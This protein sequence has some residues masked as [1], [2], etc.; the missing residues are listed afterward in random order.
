MNVQ[1][2]W[3][4]AG[5]AIAL[6]VLA[7]NF[8]VRADFAPPPWRD[9]PTTVFAHWTFTPTGTVREHSFGPDPDG[10][11]GPIAPFMGAPF[12]PGSE[13]FLMYTPDPSMPSAPEGSAGIYEFSIPN[14]VDDFLLK[15]I[16]IQLQYTFNPGPPTGPF[17]TIGP[18]M[19]F[20][21]TAPDG[22][23]PS[24]NITQKF[25]TTPEAVP[26]GGLTYQ[27]FEDWQIVPNPDWEK[28][29]VQIP[30]GIHLDWVVVD[31][32]STVPEPAAFL[33]GGLVCCVVGVA[34]TGR[35]LLRRVRSTLA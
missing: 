20:D 9:D 31:T 12:G 33:C 1:C 30:V 14:W 16:R 4:T 13:P 29:Q 5:R 15:C 22:M 32:L 27:E 25:D 19:A 17:P 11:S 18:I 34:W 24:G 6:V 3:K 10:P 28:F 26:P 2:F 7:A 8:P 35:R 21:P 23:V